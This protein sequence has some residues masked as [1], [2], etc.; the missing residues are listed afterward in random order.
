M[1][2]LDLANQ[3]MD[4]D[5]REILLESLKSESERFAG[6]AD[7]QSDSSSGPAPAIRVLPEPESCPAPPDFKPHVL[8]DYSLDEI[9]PYL[10][11]QMLLGKHLGLKGNVQK[12]L[13]AGD[14]KATSVYNQVRQ[15]QDE[16]ISKGT[17]RAHAIYRFF[18][19]YSEGNTQYILDSSRK[20][21]LEKIDFP[22]KPSGDHLCAAD[23]VASKAAGLQD[24]FAMFVTTCSAPDFAERVEA[25]KKSGE[26]VKAHI[27][28][29][30]AL[31]TAEAFA[32]L[33]HEKIRT[34]WGISDPPGMTLQE[35]IQAKY[36][37]I[38]LSFG[39]PACPNLEDQEILF[40]LL[41][42][43]SIGVQLTEGHMMEPESSVSALVYHNPLAKYFVADS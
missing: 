24:N 16:A 12:L 10:S 25:L 9:F 28:Q 36:Q 26:Y 23:F 1:N 17:L 30:L 41:K 18:P 31:E 14:E 39:Y 3:V 6:K 8:K 32:E 42:P 20:E 5:R 4:K 37:G 40:R 33:L 34:M 7:T 19:T 43:E 15:V 29:A 35:K 38:R 27:L 21:I 11:L 2:G 13:D 22:R